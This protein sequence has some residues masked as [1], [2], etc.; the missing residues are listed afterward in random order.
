[1]HDLEE[2]V[3]LDTSANIHDNP[4]TLS[5]AQV[6]S[7]VDINPNPQPPVDPRSNALGN[8]YA[9]FKSQVELAARNFTIDPV[10]R[11]KIFGTFNEFNVIVCGPPRVGKSTLINAICGH[12]QAKT[13]TGLGSCTKVIHRYVLRGKHDVDGETM[14]YIYNFW[15][16]PGFESWGKADIEFNFNLIM[17]KPKSDPLCMIFCAS[18][19]AFANTQQVEW[20]L[21]VC[22]KRHIFCALVVTNKWAGQQLQRLGVLENYKK[23]L[24]KYEKQTGEEKDGVT[25]FG[26]TGLCTMVNAE[27]Y[28][29][30]ESNLNK[31]QE[32]INELIRGIMLGLGEEEKVFHWC[33]IA[34]QNRGFVSNV[35]AAMTIAVETVTSAV[36]R[37]ADYATDWMNYLTNAFPYEDTGDAR[38]D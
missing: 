3:L 9:I 14:K 12:R 38:A 4:E 19:G 21:D 15:D 11:N 24:S 2:Q 10:V 35:K 16:T 34:I 23:L 20:V 37:M 7:P 26:N 13:A 18:P 1:M 17:S 27:P 5:K 30:L 36:G 28:V 25:P 29:D 32:G 22:V 6:G 31:P 33:M 8:A